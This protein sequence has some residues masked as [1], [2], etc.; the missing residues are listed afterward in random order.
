MVNSRY[1]FRALLALVATLI[2]ILFS[3]NLRAVELQEYDLKAAFLYNYALYVEWPKASASS[4]DHFQI[5]LLGADP[6]DGNLEK[7]LGPKNVVGKPILI[8]KLSSAKEAPSCHMLYISTSEKRNLNEI[9]SVTNSHSILTI[10]DIPEFT[11]K[12]GMINFV[13]NEN[14]VRFFINN[15]AATEAGLKISSQLLKLA[16][17]ANP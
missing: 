4:T 15:T 7:V 9:F 17:N 11:K 13:L 1:N 10:S 5:C 16:L 12:G 14:K 2:A 8:R 6:F 3:V